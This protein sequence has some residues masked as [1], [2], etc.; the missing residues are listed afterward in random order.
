MKLG[1]ARQDGISSGYRLGSKAGLCDCSS[2]RA[3]DRGWWLPS[4]SDASAHLV[5]ATEGAR[6]TL[7]GDTSIPKSDTCPMIVSLGTPLSL[8]VSQLDRHY[9]AALLLPEFRKPSV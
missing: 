8:L 9:N 5:R 2:L 6:K 1:R 3:G 4:I 7:P